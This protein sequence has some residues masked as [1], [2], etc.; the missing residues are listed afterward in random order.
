MKGKLFLAALALIGFQLAKAQE[1]T[2]AMDSIKTK[3]V[4]LQKQKDAEKLNWNKS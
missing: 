4:E 1:V 3:E 2:T